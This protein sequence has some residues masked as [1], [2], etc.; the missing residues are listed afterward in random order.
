MF[1]K[2]GFCTATSLDAESN[3]MSL[4]FLDQNQL[5]TCSHEEALLNYSSG[6]APG[7]LHFYKVSRW[8]LWS[9]K[10]NTTLVLN[11]GYILD[12]PGE[13]GGREEERKGGRK[14]KKQTNNN[15]PKTQCPGPNLG[16]EA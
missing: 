7:K 2:F 13:E 1:L 10:L 4:S 14:E 3:G 16:A 9:L 15:N 5:G 11:L 6:L 8:F 12:F